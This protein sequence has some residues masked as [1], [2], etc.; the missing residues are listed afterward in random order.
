[1][2]RKKP[3]READCAECRMRDTGSAEHLFIAESST[4]GSAVALLQLTRDIWES[5][6]HIASPHTFLKIIRDGRCSRSSLQHGL[7]RRQE[8]SEVRE[9]HRNLIFLR[10]TVAAIQHSG[11]SPTNYDFYLAV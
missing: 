7:Q 6:F 2:S 10:L 5:D 4:H 8:V 1:M 3:H 11:V 9:K